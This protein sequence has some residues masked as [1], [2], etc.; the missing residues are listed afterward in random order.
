MEGAQWVPSSSYYRK[1]N[2]TTDISICNSALVLIGGTD[3]AINSF[4]DDTREARICAQLYPGTR[5]YTI[6][7]YPWKFTLGQQALAKL[8]ETPLFDY[9]NAFQL[10]TDPK[11]VQAIKVSDE[12]GALLNFGLSGRVTQ[13]FRILEDK[14][15]TN[16][17]QVN[18]LFQFVPVEATFPPYFVEVLE[19]SMA[20]KLAFAL[21]QDESLADRMAVRLDQRIRK[22]RHIDSR[23]D[24]PFSF[25][26]E[27]LVLTS[28]R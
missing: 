20:E 14:L 7:R 3:N 1:N 23:N 16:A 25:P 27:E 6:S 8:A 19:F 10:P 28:V 9:A 11:L 5:D 18:I 17:T 22:A 15:L 2:M 24:P 13:S 21:E 26:R 12:V 4:D